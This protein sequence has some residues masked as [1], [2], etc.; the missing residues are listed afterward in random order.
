MS[1]RSPKCQLNSFS[2]NTE[3]KATVRMSIVT[4]HSLR[5]WAVLVTFSHCDKMPGRVAGGGDIHL[6]SRFQRVHSVV[7]EVCAPEQNVV[8]AAMCGS[9]NVWQW[10]C[11]TAAMCGSGNVWQRSFL[12]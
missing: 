4:I 3:P 2:G 8:A 9:G 11:V 12:L 1:T 10:Q 5:R 7:V 6:G